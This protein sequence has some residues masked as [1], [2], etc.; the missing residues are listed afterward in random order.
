MGG[1]QKVTQFVRG[2]VQVC[3]ALA[4]AMAPH[5]PGVLASSVLLQSSSDA[6]AKSKLPQFA[7]N[8]V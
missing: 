6:S 7:V 4:C 3:C 8:L 2:R 1:G 5:L